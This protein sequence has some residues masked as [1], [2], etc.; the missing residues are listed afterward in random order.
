MSRLFSLR[1]RWLGVIVV[2]LT[3]GLS[4]CGAYARSSGWPGLTVEDASTAYLSF[5]QGVY[6]VD[7]AQGTL[8][9]RFPEKPSRSQTFYAPPVLTPDGQLLAASYDHNLYSLNP[10]NGQLLWTFAGATNH[11]IGAPLVTEDAIYAPNADGGLYAL[12]LQGEQRWVFRSRHALWATPATDGRRLYLPAMDHHLYALHPADGQVIWQVDLG[13]AMASPPALA[14]GVLYVGTFADKVVA[15]NA[16][17]GTVRWEAATNAWVWSTPLLS[18]GRLFFGDVSGTFY[19]LNAEDGKTLWSIQPD[20]PIVGAP[21]AGDDT[22]Y[23]TTEQGTLYAVSAEDGTVR[24]IYAMGVTLQTG[25]VVAEAL[26]LVAPSQ[27]D[28]LLVALDA[29][30]GQ[31]RWNI[32][33][34]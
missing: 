20:G 30:T 3:L 10:E 14:D 23:F 27:G 11:Y 21:A 33:A 5:N 19:A 24:W 1:H 18:Q 9:W 16:E 26:L 7:L 17:D 12:T 28:Q 2:F 29:K 34:P 32:P 31:P 15:V 4:A 8:R 22:L 13:G 25:P 6:A